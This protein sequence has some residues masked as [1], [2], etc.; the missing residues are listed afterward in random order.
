MSHGPFLK[1]C[2]ISYISYKWNM[3][4]KSIKKL[5]TNSP[6]DRN[7]ETVSNEFFF[8]FSI[9]VSHHLFLT[10]EILSEGWKTSEPEDRNREIV[11]H[12]LF[13]SYF[14]S[15]VLHL[16]YIAKVSY[17]EYKLMWGSKSWKLV[18]GVVFLFY[19]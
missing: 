7:R 1:S 14:K 15:C 5:D 17:E 19:I 11:S 2:F 8:F 12:E 13:K 18:S 16:S 9:F 4:Q 10:L 3:L 6:E